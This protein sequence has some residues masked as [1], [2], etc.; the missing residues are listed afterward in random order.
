MP[1]N[2]WPKSLIPVPRKTIKLRQAERQQ[3]LRDNW[4]CRFTSAW[5]LQS[6]SRPE[7]DELTARSTITSDICPSNLV[8]FQDTALLSSARR[9]RCREFQSIPR[10]C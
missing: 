2:E 9:L 4:Y 6:Y 3:S 7:N 10:S 5:L 8:L 1:E